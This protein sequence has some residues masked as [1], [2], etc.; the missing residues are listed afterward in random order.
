MHIYLL[1]L[2]MFVLRNVDTIFSF[3]NIILK[4]FCDFSINQCLCACMHVLSPK[5]NASLIYK[6]SKVQNC[7]QVI[8]DM[9]GHS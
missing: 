6:G 8:T 3:L 4:A 5:Q 2:F 7:T 9:T 1:F